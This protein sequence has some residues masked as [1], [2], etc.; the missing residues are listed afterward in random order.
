MSFS[1]NTKKTLLSNLQLSFVIID[2]VTDNQLRFYNVLILVRKAEKATLQLL[3]NYVGYQEKVTASQ[4]GLWNK[5]SHLKLT[6]C[7]GTTKHKS[8]KKQMAS[9]PRSISAGT[10]GEASI[11]VSDP[12]HL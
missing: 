3:S 10:F 5:L 4:S 2:V 11:S 1:N 6:V 9:Q 7:S 12:A 8:S